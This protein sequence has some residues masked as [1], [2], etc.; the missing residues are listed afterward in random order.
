ME[1]SVYRG[2]VITTRAANSGFVARLSEPGGRKLD[3]PLICMPSRESAH[4][5][6]QKFV[7]WYIKLSD[8]SQNTAEF[9]SSS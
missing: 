6:A 5:Y 4:R 1:T 8:R 7:D 9:Q 3:G 2:W